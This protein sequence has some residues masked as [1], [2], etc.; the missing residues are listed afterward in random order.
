MQKADEDASFCHLR[1]LILSVLELI[2][3]EAVTALQIID[4]LHVLGR[5]LEV[6]DVVVLGDVGGVR[7]AGDGDDAA[8]QVPAQDDLIGG[9]LVGLCDVLDDLV[10]RECL[11]ARTATAQWE[12]CFE[13]GAELGDVGLYAAALVVGMRL[14]L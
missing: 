9:S 2:R 1:P 11:D 13:D 12:P 7:R 14:V 8:L 5:Q 4:A 6:E 10:L 3:R